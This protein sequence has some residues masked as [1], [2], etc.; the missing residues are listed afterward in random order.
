[1]KYQVKIMAKKKPPSPTYIP[2]DPNR[3]PV[4]I[5]SDDVHLTKL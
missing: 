2:Y 4:I 5:I 3:K 1:M